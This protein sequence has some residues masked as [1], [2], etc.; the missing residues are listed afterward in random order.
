MRF[1]LEPGSLEKTEP[2]IAE[3]RFFGSDDVPSVLNPGSASGND[4]RTVGQVVDG[5]N[6][7]SKS[8]RGVIEKA[9]AIR[10]LDALQS[11]EEMGKQLGLFLVSLFRDLHAS[12]G[13]IVTHV[14]SRDGRAH[15]SDQG[16]E[17]LAI[18][19]YP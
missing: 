8:H 16:I 15:A 13:F 5:V 17:G 19:K 10:F 9:A 3:G 7:A 18:G 2:E 4:R 14:V 6:V 11:I 1:R 12:A